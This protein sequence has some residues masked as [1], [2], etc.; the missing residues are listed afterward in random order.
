MAGMVESNRGPVAG[1]SP[2]GSPV[3][4]RQP[5]DILTALLDWES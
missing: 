4:G 5:L 3:C 2:G 1:G